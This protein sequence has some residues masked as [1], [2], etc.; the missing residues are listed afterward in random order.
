M[1]VTLSTKGQLVIPKEI[2]KALSLRAGAKFAVELYQGQIVLK[3]VLDTKRYRA[4]I[5]R[6]YGK[7]AQGGLLNELATERQQELR[8]DEA[9]GL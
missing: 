9:R 7:F 5:D 8:R 2:R 6:L 4:V 3:P 1:T